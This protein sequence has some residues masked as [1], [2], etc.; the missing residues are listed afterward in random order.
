MFEITDD[1]VTQI[2]LSRE[3]LG[4]D[5]LRLRISARYSPEYGIAYKMGFD[6][7]YETDIKLEINGVKVVFDRDSEKMVKGMKIDYRELDGQMQIVFENPNDVDP[8]DVDHD[9]P[10]EK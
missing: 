4:E 9:A 1:A 7:D 6:D 5:N 10:S 3:Q 2:K 8:K